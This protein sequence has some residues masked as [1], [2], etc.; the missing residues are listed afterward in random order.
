MADQFVIQP[1]DTIQVQIEPTVV[2]VVTVQGPQGP[3]GAAGPAFEG[4]AW[5][6]GSGPPGVIVGA[7]V[8]DYYMDTTAGTIYRLG[9]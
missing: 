5:F 3:P 9:D 2:D 8:G 6:Y 7:K 1:G 4:T